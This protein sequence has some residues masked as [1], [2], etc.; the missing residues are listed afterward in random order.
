MEKRGPKPR[1][2]AQ[3]GRKRGIDAAWRPPARLRGEARKAWVH[4]VGL[5]AA[6]GNLDRTDPTLVE[7]YAVNVALMRQACEAIDTDGLTVANG[8]GG[9][10]PNP[11]CAVLNS[12][13]MRLKAIVNDLGLCPASSKHAAGKGGTPNRSSK[14]GDEL[15]IV[16]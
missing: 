12:A 6:A 9:I 10:S 5:L 2:A 7:A 13:T 3:S 1:T 8:G 14:W 16:G 15:G 4:V 11:A